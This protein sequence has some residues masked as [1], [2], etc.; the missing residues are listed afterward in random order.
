MKCLC[1]HHKEFKYLQIQ[2]SVIVF[3]K[4]FNAIISKIGNSHCNMLYYN[5]FKITMIFLLWEFSF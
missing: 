1:F 2:S 4:L 3:T 5:A